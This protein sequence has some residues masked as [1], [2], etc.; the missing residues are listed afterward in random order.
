MDDVLR[1]YYRRSLETEADMKHRLEAQ[2]N[3]LI[4]FRKLREGI[5]SVSRRDRFALEVYETSLFLAAV[6]GSLRDASA[7]AP[8]LVPDLYLSCPGPHRNIVHAIL[9]SSMHHLLT[10]YPSQVPFQQYLNFIPHHL[11]PKESAARKWLTSL[12]ARLRSCQHVS[13]ERETR[14]S[15]ILRVLEQESS[16]PEGNLGLSAVLAAVDGLRA[17]ARDSAWTVMRSA[18]RELVCRADSMNTR[19]WLERSLCLQSTVSETFTVSLDEFLEQQ[20]LRGAVRAKEGVEG[21]WIVSK[22]RS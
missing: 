5:S 19:R 6:F 3:V 7:V 2:E 12:A 16:E 9:V 15:T 21:H 22:I 11:F 1:K 4:L 17:K 14:R 18:Y 20:K 10:E 13:F 8:R